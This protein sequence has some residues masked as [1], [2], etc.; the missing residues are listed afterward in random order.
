MAEQIIEEID[1]QQIDS[2]ANT[3]FMRIRMWRHFHEFDRIRNHPDLPRLLT[4]ALPS[5]V[6]RWIRESLPSP[7]TQPAVETVLESVETGPSVEP[8]PNWHDWLSWLK[9]GDEVA[10]ELFLTQRPSQSVDQIS[11]GDIMRFVD[12]LEGFFLDDALRSRHVE[13]LAQGL[14]EFLQDFVREQEFPR[15]SFG[16]LYLAILRLW[17]A[18]YAG[19]STRK[20]HCHVLLELASAALRS[21]CGISE[22]PEIIVTWWKARPVP[23]QLPFLLDAIELLDREHPDRDVPANFWV[24]AA[25]LVRQNPNYLTYSERELWRRIGQRLGMDPATLQR[26]IPEA[27]AGDAV[28]PLQ[29]SGLR[30]IAIVCMR[31]KQAREAAEMIAKRT[32][33]A[34][35]IVSS[36]R[37]GHETESAV[38][39]DVI[40][41]VWMATSHA[42]LRAFD[43]VPRRRLA[44]VQGTGAASIV[45][46]L[47]HWV[48]E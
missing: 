44:Y 33:A 40:L 19:I 47:E 9:S 20:E 36:G 13:L 22:I 38:Q 23:A 28:D 7:A 29:A 6:E 1:Q 37:A 43:K 30:K 3:Q 32:G 46:T 39:A 27:E 24:E 35:S 2:A 17:G 11:P 12:A 4:Q 14:A 41:L 26:Y 8:E 48:F 31:E 42:V 15:A 10:A 16:K 34:V 21:N 18:L 25:E 5:N 45:R